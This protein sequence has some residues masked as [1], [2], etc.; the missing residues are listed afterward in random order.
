MRATRKAGAGR[1]GGGHL[2]CC[3]CEVC[4]AGE[5]M[6]LAAGFGVGFLGFGFGVAPSAAAPAAAVGVAASF[7]ASFV[8]I[9]A[10]RSVGQLHLVAPKPILGTVSVRSL[11][12]WAD[13]ISGWAKCFPPF[14]DGLAGLH[15]APASLL[16]RHGPARRRPRQPVAQGPGC[17]F[18]SLAPS[19][20]GYLDFGRERQ[21][22]LGAHPPERPHHVHVLRV[23]G[24]AADPALYGAGRSVLPGTAEWVRARPVLPEPRRRPPAHRRRAEPRADLVRFRHPALQLRRRTRRAGRLGGGQ[25]TCGPGD[26][27]GDEESRQHR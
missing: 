11:E 15:R 26:V 8:N 25:G 18:A 16:R 7:P 19:T 22:D 3:V 24:L 9:W 13:N 27:P 6:S 20:V 14:T 23:R 10:R 1:A 5:V 4:W 12:T 17:L 21:R 2:A